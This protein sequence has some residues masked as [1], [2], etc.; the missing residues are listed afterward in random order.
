[1]SE[2]QNHQHTLETYNDFSGLHDPVVNITLLPIP[3]GILS[4]QD[5]VIVFAND[6]F[7][8][9]IKATRVGETVQG[10]LDT[11]E[12]RDKVSKKINS[13]GRYSK[14]INKPEGSLRFTITQEDYMASPHYFVFIEKINEPEAEQHHHYIARKKFL[15]HLLEIVKQPKSNVNNCLCNIDIDRFSVINEKY[16]YEAGD[17][18]LNE[19]IKVIQK[20]TDGDNIIGRLGSNEFGLILKDTKLDDAVQICEVIRDIVKNVGFQWEDENIS[21]TISI[22]VIALK[23]RTRKFRSC[24][25]S[26]KL[27]NAVCTRKWPR[28][29]A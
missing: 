14:I 5:G 15:K 11:Q 18:I 4:V 26:L 17:Y 19:L 20:N 29:C 13:H 8:N 9:I 21:L 10:F 23:L 3:I 24:V 28:L 25:G 6:A 22:G 2:Q 7:R 12:A 16:G 1:M 27:G